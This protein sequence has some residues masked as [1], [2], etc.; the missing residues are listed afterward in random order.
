MKL[1]NLLRMPILFAFALC[2]PF[3]SLAAETEASPILGDSAKGREQF[4]R[5]CATCHPV[6]LGGRSNLGPNLHGV[7]GRVVGSY[8]GFRYGAPYLAAAQAGE[9]WTPERAFEYLLDPTAMFK[10]GR[11]I[12]RVRDET[13]RADLTAY[14]LSISPEYRPK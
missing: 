6:D 4:V 5:K 10:G 9:V 2:I 8:E 14:L 12:L 7:F 13:I 1:P 11:M 3:V